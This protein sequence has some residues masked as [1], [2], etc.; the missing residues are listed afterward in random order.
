M[1]TRGRLR[2]SLEWGGEKKPAPKR[3]W[4]R[5]GEQE[6]HPIAI[7]NYREESHGGGFKML[8]KGFEHRILWIS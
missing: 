2:D 6:T 3:K 4:G 1:G 7:P 8:I 5:G